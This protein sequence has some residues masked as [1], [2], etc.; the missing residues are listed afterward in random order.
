MLWLTACNNDYRMKREQLNGQATEDKKAAPKDSTTLHPTITVYIENSGSM[1]G[2]VNGSTLFKD[3]LRELLVLLKYQYDE[4]NIRV[5]FINSAIYPS[6]IPCKLE[7]LASNLNVNTIAV[8]N[9]GSSNLN[10]V[11][12]LVLS[13]T[14][15]SSI[16]IL[17]SD[18][19]YSIDGANSEELLEEAKTLTKGVFLSKSKENFQLTTTLVKMNS[20]FTGEY[21]TR[22]NQPVMLSE[23]LRPYYICIIGEDQVMEDFNSRIVFDA[24]SLQGYEDKCILTSKDYSAGNYF[25]VLTST[26]ATGRFKPIKRLT[27]S[28]AVRGIEDAEP[29]QRTN[30][31][32]SFAVA[33]DLKN[34]PVGEA[35]LADASNYELTEGNFI[36]DRIEKI[37]KKTI[38]APDWVRIQNSGASH[39]IVLKAKG[40]AAGTVTVALKK[41]LPSWIS[42]TE[43]KEG[44]QEYKPGKTF[45]FQYLVNG[46]AEAYQTVNPEQKYYLS[47]RI[48]IV[49]SSDSILGKSLVIILLLFS[50]VA[51]FLIVLKNR[52][53]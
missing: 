10:E 9:T 19:I 18:C 53:R 35:Y 41:Q 37:D 23:Q 36:V 17:L 20:S 38:D 3:A 11:F 27:S 29:N 28:T 52:K 1:A 44:E 16:S 32:F 40:P 13:K 33:V 46:I 22:A 39:L 25:S 21:W 50:I 4:R 30:E 8:G 2:Y 34:M 5:C 49:K 24:E 43:P 26:Y 7:D 6:T 14:S 12:R 51:V 15:K 47:I 31:P 48:P 45:G 42:E